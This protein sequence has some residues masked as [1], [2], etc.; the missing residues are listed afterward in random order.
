MNIVALLV[1][2]LASR[3]EDQAGV[4]EAA[5]ALRSLVGMGRFSK[6][7]AT[8]IATTIFDNA[9]IIKTQPQSVR[10]AVLCL[11]DDL[12]A[13][14]RSTLHAMGGGFI[15]GFTS[16]IETEKD[17]RNLMIA[18]SLS[19][20]V[21][22]EWDVS[23]YAESLWEG[24]TKYFPITF[25]PNPNDHIGI[26]ADDLKDRLRKCM[27]ATTLFAPRAFPLL[28]EKLDDTV[29]NVKVRA[30]FTLPIGHLY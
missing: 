13:K 4:K 27:A 23:E 2:F 29:A 10:Y 22:K 18:F 11:V 24:I 17:P 26:T 7:F 8:D 20:V 16:L 12:M 1:K 3:I 28:I 21:L 5:Q 6:L 15:D 30:V 9:G 25:R 14:C 19:E